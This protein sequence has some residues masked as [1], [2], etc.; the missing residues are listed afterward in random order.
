MEKKAAKYTSP[1][2]A[3]IKLQQYCAYQERSHVEVTAKL[4]E[5]GVYG[6]KQD[7]IVMSLIADNFLNE[8]RFAKAYAHGKFNIKNWGRIRI[9]QELKMHKISPYCLKKA[10]AE[11]EEDE[12]FKKLETI[13]E[14]KSNLLNLDDDNFK[15]RQKLFAYAHQKGYETELINRALNIFF[16]G[17]K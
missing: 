17:K 10:M 6:E 14:K 15:L 7:E 16:D 5:L 11:I 9:K 2:V 12:Y 13:I 8:E 1:E 3:L 4:Y